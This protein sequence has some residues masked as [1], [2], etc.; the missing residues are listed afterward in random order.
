MILISYC[1]P[2]LKAP[3]ASRERYIFL[4]VV[5]D[6]HLHIHWYECTIIVRLE[7][8]GI[9]S[10]LFRGQLG[11]NPVCFKGV[12]NM[13]AENEGFNYTYRKTMQPQSISIVVSS[14]NN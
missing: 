1:F 9:C 5:I 7:Q 12:G 8:M 10:S 13:N 4:T 14:L 2:A 11:G 6:W 3:R